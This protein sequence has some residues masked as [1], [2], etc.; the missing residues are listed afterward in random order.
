MKEQMKE[1]K[2]ITADSLDDVWDILGNKTDWQLR[3]SNLMETG[4]FWKRYIKRFIFERCSPTSAS[5]DT[6][7]TVIR[8]SK[9]PILGT[10]FTHH[11]KNR[12]AR[13]C[14]TSCWFSNNAFM[15]SAACVLSLSDF[16]PDKNK[17][18]I[19]HVWTFFYPLLQTLSSSIK[20][21]LSPL[22]HLKY[23]I[24]CAA[25]VPHYKIFLIT[26]GKID[27]LQALKFRFCT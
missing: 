27:C 1:E 21:Y 15:I 22:Q 20:F 6:W 18:A 24:L 26:T 9:T 10:N 23:W 11:F 7:R 12:S 13:S 25:G 19:Y 2:I 16:M 8:Y 5:S 4:R 14:N 17:S 3:S